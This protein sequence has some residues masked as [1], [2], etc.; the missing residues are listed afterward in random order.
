MQGMIVKHN[1]GSFESYDILTTIGMVTQPPS[2]ILYAQSGWMKESTSHPVNDV[3]FINRSYPS[4]VNTLL[5]S[6]GLSPLSVVNELNT[7]NTN[8]RSIQ[9]DISKKLIQLYEQCSELQD[10]YQ[11][12]IKRPLYISLNTI[13]QSVFGDSKLF[14]DELKSTVSSVIVESD[15]FISMAEQQ[16]A[17]Y[18]YLKNQGAYYFDADIPTVSKFREQQ[19]Y[20]LLS[21]QS[22][23]DSEMLENEIRCFRT[24]RRD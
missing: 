6:H 9:S 13:T 17:V 19:M 14:V 16:F 7:F 2:Q 15:G 20:S 8:A 22:I 18:I 5:Q 11:D 23:Q 1:D 10:F 21:K 12:G 24:R 3:N 4:S